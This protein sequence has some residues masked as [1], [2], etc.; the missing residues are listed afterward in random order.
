[1]SAPVDSAPVRLLE[2]L[3]PPDAT[4]DEELVDD[5]VRLADADC[6]TVSGATASATAGGTGA[7]AGGVGAGVVESDAPPPPQPMSAAATRGNATRSQGRMAGRFTSD[8]FGLDIATFNF[9]ESIGPNSGHRDDCV[10]GRHRRQ[11]PNGTSTFHDFQ[12]RAPIGAPK[13]PVMQSGQFDRPHGDEPPQS[14]KSVSM[15]RNCSSSAFWHGR[16]RGPIRCPARNTAHQV[17]SI[18]LR[19]HNRRPQPLPIRR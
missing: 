19:P 1:M 12:P 5:H 14:T 3:Q 17:N 11:G 8:R 18:T 15:H 16:G 2:P 10:P 4:Q 13:A 6:W 9:S 7:G